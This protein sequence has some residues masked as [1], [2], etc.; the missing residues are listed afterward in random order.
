M[1][2][3]ALQFS[4][5][6]WNDPITLR[7]FSKYVYADN[8][9]S[10]EDKAAIKMQWPNSV[11]YVDEMEV[12]DGGKGR[13]R[14]APRSFD[15]HGNPI[16]DERVLVVEPVEMGAYQA[17]LNYQLDQ[18]AHPEPADTTPSTPH[19]EAAHDESH[20]ACLTHPPHPDLLRLM[21]E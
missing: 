18:L 10:P 1:I 15:R 5:F 12:S 21:S 4:E 16:G 14:F 19:A 9:I 20:D 17:P 11:L 2:V 8:Y 13:V 6:E 7:T 3:Y